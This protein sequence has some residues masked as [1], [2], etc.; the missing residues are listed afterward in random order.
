[1]YLDSSF[2][3]IIEKKSKYGNKY[4]INFTY[5]SKENF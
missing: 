4:E 2:H 5:H 1:M 3:L